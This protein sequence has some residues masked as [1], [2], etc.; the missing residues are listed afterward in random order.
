MEFHVSIFHF[1]SSTCKIDM[2]HHELGMHNFKKESTKPFLPLMNSS[3]PTTENLA[4]G[5]SG[6][7]PRD[8]P[9]EK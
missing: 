9:S 3:T 5:I 4:H 8:L 2:K 6:T 7:E 1:L